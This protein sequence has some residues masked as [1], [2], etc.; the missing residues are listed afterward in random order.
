MQL[1]LND[2]FLYQETEQFDFENPPVDPEELFVAMRD[3][4]VASRGIGLAANQV[5]LPYSVFVVG[6]PDDPSSYF[7]AFNPRIVHYSEEKTAFDEGCLSFKNLFMKIV[8]PV[9]IRARFAT[10]DGSYDTI[11][12]TGL[13]SRIFQHEYDHLK[14]IVFHKRASLL[15]RERGHRKMIKA[16][17]QK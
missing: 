13:T 11:K 10:W 16:N 3:F 6:M 9:E 4:A 5:G 15:E 12:M 17:R 1:S 7:A 2:E 14:G 8:R